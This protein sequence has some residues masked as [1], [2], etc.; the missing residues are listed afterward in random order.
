MQAN[1]LSGTLPRFANI[2]VYLLAMS[3]ASQASETSTNAT[4]ATIANANGGFLTVVDTTDN[5][6]IEPMTNYQQ[7]TDW[8]TD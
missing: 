2:D 5:K 6:V 1:R 8:L 3:Q 7:S 4:N